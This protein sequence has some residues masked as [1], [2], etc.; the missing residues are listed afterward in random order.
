MTVAR[1]LALPAWT[2]VVWVPR[3]RNIWVDD[4]LSVSGQVLRTLWAV[5][6][7]AFAVGALWAWWRG[8][9]WARPWQMA[10]VAWTVGFWAVRGAQIALADHDAGFIAVHT[11]LALGS[12][13]LAVWSW[14]RHQ[15]AAAE[16]VDAVHAADQG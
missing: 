2:L 15:S 1:R 3:V 14:P 10:F 8:A 16:P 12:I 7:L 9:S 13:G 4:A 5:L 6:F 11:V